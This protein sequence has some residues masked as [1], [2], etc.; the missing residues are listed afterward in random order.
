MTEDGGKHV[1]ACM[2]MH[3]CA[4]ACM[5]T[6]FRGG[7]EHGRFVRVP[8]H[9]LNVGVDRKGRHRG[10]AAHIN[11]RGER[12]G[13]ECV[14]CVVF[15]RACVCVRVASNGNKRSCFCLLWRCI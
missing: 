2:R 3:A 5:R 15:A 1:R 6:G 12:W 14:S 10:G 9:A 8:A 4:R 13:A 7:H 11:L